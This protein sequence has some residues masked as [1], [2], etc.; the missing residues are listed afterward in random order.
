MHVFVLL[1]QPMLL[2]LQVAMLP[3]LAQSAWTAVSMGSSTGGGS[4]CLQSS[5][6]S[7]GEPKQ[8]LVT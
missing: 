3:M 5:T 6:T 1:A 8:H 7:A 4:C 2:L